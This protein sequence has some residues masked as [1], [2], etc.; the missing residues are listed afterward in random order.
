MQIIDVK[1]ML[2]L[3]DLKNKILNNIFNLE[4]SDIFKDINFLINELQ[5]YNTAQ[6]IDVNNLNVLSLK[7]FQ[8]KNIKKE[9]KISDIMLSLS[10]H[11]SA[12]KLKNLSEN[13]LIKQIHFKISDFKFL[14]NM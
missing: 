8:L 14:L 13:V 4:S 11:T 7:N 10:Q 6:L 3:A 2:I 1:A 12:S 9:K 5:I